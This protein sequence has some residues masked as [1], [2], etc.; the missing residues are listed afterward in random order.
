MS[1]KINIDFMFELA[2]NKRLP[3]FYKLA[4]IRSNNTA[5]LN[6]K[7]TEI[8]Q[9]SNN[10]CTVIDIPSH[11]K[12]LK[13]ELNS[14]IGMKSVIQ[15]K[16]YFIDLT[17]YRNIDDY[18]KDRFSRSSRQALKSSKKRLETCFDISYKMYFGEI[19]KEEYNSLFIQFY[20]MLKLRAIEKGI[21]N[22]NLQHWETYTKEV[23]DMIL[24][25]EA[26]LFVIHDGNTPIN[27]SLN[28]HLKEIVFLFI[29]T[30]NIDYSKFRIGHTNWYWLIDWF[31]KNN[32]KFVDFSKGNTAYKK[33]WTNNEYDFKYHIFYNKLNTKSTLKAKILEQKLKLKQSLRDN[34]INDYF[35]S[36][37]DKL[38]GNKKNQHLK[39]HT[40][41]NIK[42]L[43]KNIDVKK[44]D[45]QQDD[46]FSFLKP[47][48][49]Q[50][51]FLSFQNIIDIEVFNSVNS[52]QDFFISSPKEILYL[53]VD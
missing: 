42:R 12:L 2:F 49:Y 50:Y 5:L 44:I 52:K 51:L 13:K 14:N 53:V 48:I 22:R 3:E 6:H 47:I 34:N 35:Y 26:S 18:I 7:G 15:Y 25:K 24:K 28:M 38:K 9:F 36:I 39:N 40:F 31:I 11:L 32:I 17:N 41:K 20:E 10:T 45:V 30:Y 37:L 46:Q 29:T 21:N 16:G 1:D 19:N 33:R 8:P 27:I 4:S 43:P 23:Y